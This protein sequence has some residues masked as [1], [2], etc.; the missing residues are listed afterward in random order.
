[1]TVEH[2]LEVAP[3]LRVLRRRLDY[4]P[5]EAHRTRAFLEHQLADLTELMRERWLAGDAGWMT[6]DEARH[7]AALLTAEAE[8]DRIGA[9]AEVRGERLVFSGGRQGEH[10]LDLMATSPVRARSAWSRYLER[11]P[12]VQ[13]TLFEM[14][15]GRRRPR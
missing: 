6:D 11:C 5:L 14:V 2:F 8:A 9:H 15:F 7:L 10:Q 12:L 4:T 1:M 3:E 13:Q